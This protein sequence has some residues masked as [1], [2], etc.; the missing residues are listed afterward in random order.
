MSLPRIVASFLSKDQEFQVMQA[1]DAQA[2]GTRAGFDIE[3]IY[4]DQNAIQQIHQLFK[5]IH[6]PAEER[7]L[8]IVVETVVGEGL[9]RV[10]RNAARAGISWVLLNRGVTYLDA[11]RKEYPRLAIATVSGD[12][13][14]MG[15]IQGRQFRALLPKGGNVLYITGPG[16][17]SA[18]KDRLQGAREVVEGSGIQLAH[19]GGRLDGSRCHEVRHERAP[20]QDRG[21]AE[22]R[23]RRSAKRQHGRGRAQG[24]PRHSPRLGARP[25]HRLRRPSRR[26]SATRED[27]RALGHGHR[28]FQR[29]P[30]HR[31]PGS[32]VEDEG[33]AAGPGDTDPHVLSARGRFD[34]QRPQVVGRLSG[35]RRPPV[36]RP[37]Q[38]TGDQGLSDVTAKVE[39]RRCYPASTLVYRTIPRRAP[40]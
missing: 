39:D 9:E 12:Q 4:A 14:A 15:R 31:P 1:V 34:R 3:V 25:L 20:A 28:S 23:P 30:G 6:I 19:R 33:A 24:P 16:D 17:T 32:L 13:L 40:G 18:A 35:P 2:T 5:F 22:A 26:R 36:A 29:R 10:A 11:L 7:P 21:H 8:A 37:E 38:G 27:E